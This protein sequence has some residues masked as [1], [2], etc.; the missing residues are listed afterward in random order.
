MQFD[1]V[2]ARLKSL[3]NPK[4]VAGMARF[5]I[6]PDRA[7]GISIPDLRKIAK[8]TGKDHALAAR[9]WKTGIHE[10]RIL[11]SMVDEPDKVT[12]AQGDRWARQ[13]NSWDLCDQCCSNLFRK[14]SFAYKKP[15]QWSREKPEFLKRGGFALMATLA[16]G[17][18]E[19]KNERFLRFLPLI[20]REATDGRNY[21]KKS[22]NWAL[23]QIGKRNT[24]LNKAAVREARVLA[25]MDSKSGRW[26][27]ADALRELTSPAVIK[28]LKH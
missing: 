26:I 1:E 24:F 13:F 4:N 8:E 3:A 12:E 28:R 15:A 16:V 25:K 21:V 14:T 9:L 10:A 23:R 17:D 5:G 20:R 22:V 27:A 19:A 11:A 6:N 7:Y 2:L 18:K